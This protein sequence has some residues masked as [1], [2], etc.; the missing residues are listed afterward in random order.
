[1]V[2]IVCLIVLTTCVLFACNEA[3]KPSTVFYE[4]MNTSEI[5]DILRRSDSYSLD[6][7]EDQKQEKYRFILKQGYTISE[8]DNY[9][10][11][12]I[13]GTNV[14]TINYNSTDGYSVTYEPLTDRF[15]LEVQ[16]VFDEYITKLKDTFEDGNF[17]L[18]TE[19]KIEIVD[20]GAAVIKHISEN[21]NYE[22]VV[23]EAY[24]FNLDKTELYTLDSGFDYKA[25][26]KQK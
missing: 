17:S 5:F 24:I 26:A 6:I 14:Y 22:L 15:Y 16:N 18:Q 4:G 23:Y 7:N 25:V 2:S 10:C 1:M 12:F 13:E 20:D 21:N 19:L 9:I 8:V 11:K 3:K